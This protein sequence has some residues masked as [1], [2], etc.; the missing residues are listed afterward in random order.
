MCIHLEFDEKVTVDDS[1]YILDSVSV[2]F[3]S[4]FPLTRGTLDRTTFIALSLL[5][6]AHEAFG[7]LP[8]GAGAAG[9]STIY[10]QTWDQ[11]DNLGNSDADPGGSTTL[12]KGLNAAGGS[13]AALWQGS[14]ATA[15]DGDLIELGYYKLNA[16]TPNNSGT[17]LFAGTWT[18]LTTKT[19]IGHVYDT[20]GWSD[21]SKAG[22][23][24]FDATF[25]RN[26]SNVYSGT[27]SINSQSDSPHPIS[28]DTPPGL[29]GTLDGNLFDLDFA[30]D[31]GGGG[32]SHQI[33]LGIRF[34]DISA[35]NNVGWNGTNS[36]GTAGK[37]NTATRYQTIMHSGN[38]W[39][40]DQIAGDNSADMYMH[41]HANDGS[42]DSNLVFEF[43][44]SD[45]FSANLSKVGTG[46]TRI[47]NDDYVATIAYHDGSGDL[48]L[49]NGGLGSAV[50]SGF[51]GSGD[52]DGANDANHFTIH[53]AAGNTGNDA[54]NFS[55]NIYQD[56]STSTDL[57][58]MKTGAGEQVLSGNVNASDSNNGS[59]SAFLDIQE[60][61]VILKPGS[62][63][64]Q[65]IEYLTGAGSGTRSLTLDNTSEATQAIELGFANTSTTQT[66]SGTV[67]LEGSGS[68][69]TI[70][71]VSSTTP[72]EANYGKEQVLSGIVSSTANNSLT[73]SGL[74]RLMLSGDNTF[75]GGATDVIIKDGTLVA[76][77][78][79]ALGGA[80]TAV[81]IDKGKL[82]IGDGNNGAVTLHSGTTITGSAVGK[83]VVGGDGT[84]TNLTI[85]SATSE[86][87]VVAPGRGISSSLSST[88]S[89]QQVTLATGG[90]A[91]A[92]GDLT[93]TNLTLNN[94]GVYD[95]EITDFTGSAG[96]GFD[97]LK[98]GSIT[99]GSGASDSF[100]VNAFSVASNGAAGA[101]SN[102]GN[103]DGG[104]NGILFL[105]SVNNQ[106][107]DVTWSHA[108]HTLTSGS[109]QQSSYFDVDSRAYNYHNGNINGGW[110][111]WYNGSGDFYLRYS[112]VPEPSTYVMVTGL[113]MLPG[114]RFLRR[115]R[116]G[117][118][119]Q[120]NEK[121]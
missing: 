78:A 89:Q 55:G 66:F 3:K 18:P 102:L 75:D 60:G 21:T 70:K 38:D 62:S 40:W 61:T 113:L 57:T 42:A 52:V 80:S 35:G 103:H 119:D 29:G 94:G 68:T 74:G 15:K 121:I 96:T 86:V 51:A 30:S 98:F 81:R 53:S 72:N 65:K 23:F 83:S 101:I 63:K 2:I 84:I 11:V 92:M 31:A 117:V 82:E 47:V 24:F 95:W 79:D 49:A 45:A 48:N 106:H 107:S 22:E 112:A 34:Y 17:N 87:D 97:V 43:D 20:T 105:D 44:N 58:I 27:A 7:T 41:L 109:W 116:K 67:A 59:A 104:G 76:A 39:K 14:G 54:P 4:I 1:G 111:V 90:A 73:K 37:T 93:V 8:T 56:S 5:F 32:N 12:L 50:V 118:N 28:N 110:G 77:H 115:F 6:V 13:A 33:R 99:F 64:T 26:T 108:N 16:G 85:G 19:T 91:K 9:Q 10:V 69:N 88:S 120:E 100:A 36:S 114:L 46:D 25:T 71:V